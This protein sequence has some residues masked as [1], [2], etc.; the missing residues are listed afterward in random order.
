M[1]VRSSWLPA[2]LLSPL[3][4]VNGVI[5]PPF[6]EPVG[7]EVEV[8]ASVKA[9]AFFFAAFSARRF[10]FAAEGGIVVWEG[11]LIDAPITKISIRSI[12]V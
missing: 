4:L 6:T 8:E 1:L 5:V 10:C 12:G 9:D 7:V 11:A 2:L 3:I